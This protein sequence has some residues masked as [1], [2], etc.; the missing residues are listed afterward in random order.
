[1]TAGNT[2]DH[3]TVEIVDGVASV[4][5]VRSVEAPIE[6]VWQALIDEHDLTAWLAPA[7]IGAGVGGSVEVAFD[8]G[9]VTGSVTRWE[10]PR[11]LEYTWVMADHADSIVRF[12]LAED[13]GA[14]VLELLHT[15]LPDSMARGYGA[16]WHAYLDRLTDQTAGR[17]VRDWDRRFGELIGNYVS[18]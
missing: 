5:F 14:T 11:L 1:M 2:T 3:G 8:D 18:D 4:H 15:R 6:R 13:G 10:P 16:G 7:I 12:E 17:T 9:P